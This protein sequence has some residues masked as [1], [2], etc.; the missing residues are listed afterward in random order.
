[1]LFEE[2][3]YY[4]GDGYNILTYIIHNTGLNSW[5]V[6]DKLGIAIKWESASYSSMAQIISPGE[7]RLIIKLLSD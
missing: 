7:T 5:L 1:M 3:Q 2:L 4:Y 6:A